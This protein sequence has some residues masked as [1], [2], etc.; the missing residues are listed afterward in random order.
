VRGQ[1]ATRA[2]LGGVLDVAALGRRLT[3]HRAGLADHGE[4]LWACVV[5]DG[6]LARW[7]G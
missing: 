5:L 1:P 2:R 6:F 4:L 7:A 3:A